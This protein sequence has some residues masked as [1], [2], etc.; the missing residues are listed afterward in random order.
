MK[1]GSPLLALLG[2]S[3]V[4]QGISDIRS[5]HLPVEIWIVR[6]QIRDGIVF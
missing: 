4:A 2:D 5:D 6:S 3:K 1:I